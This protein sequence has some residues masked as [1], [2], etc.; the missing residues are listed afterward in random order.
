M[1]LLGG[2][3]V[4]ADLRDTARDV[5]PDRAEGEE[6][7]FEDCFAAARDAEGVRA[8]QRA[9]ACGAGFETVFAQCEG[10]VVEV[11]GADLN[12]GAELFG[13]ERRED[14]V[15]LGDFEVDAGVAGEG[16]LDDGGEEAAVGAVVVGEDFFLAAEELD[17]VPEFFEVGGVIDVG[18]GF[19]HLRNGLREDGAAEA[20]FAAAQIDQEQDGVSDGIVIAKRAGALGRSIRLDCFVACGSSQ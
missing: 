4:V 9:D 5:G 20:V 6:V 15:A 13:K 14:F 7:F 1:L 17:C 11:V 3:G 8:G 18:R 19:A 2:G 12:H 16:H 10:N